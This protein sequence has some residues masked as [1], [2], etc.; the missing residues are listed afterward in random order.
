MGWRSWPKVAS[1]RHSRRFAAQAICGRILG[2]RGKRPQARF[3]RES[4]AL[5]CRIA[6]DPSTI[7]LDR[8]YLRSKG[9]SRAS[10]QKLREQDTIA[11]FV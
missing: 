5:W 10:P 2:A 11:R 3:G 7:A 4:T 1:L 9:D 6:V 8:L